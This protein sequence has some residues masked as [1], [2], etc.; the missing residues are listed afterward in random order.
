MITTT[1]SCA[2][3][4]NLNADLLIRILF[5]V[6]SAS[7]D[8]LVPVSVLKSPACIFPLTSQCISVLSRRTILS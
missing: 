3:H 5:L 4:I 6:V 7:S 1:S 8:A 2:E